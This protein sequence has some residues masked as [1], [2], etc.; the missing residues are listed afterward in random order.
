MEDSFDVEEM[1]GESAAIFNHFITQ[2][3]E[4][5]SIFWIRLL[6]ALDG[7]EAAT[8]YRQLKRDGKKRGIVEVVKDD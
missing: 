4:G 7:E 5:V 2:N 8:S 3:Y 1:T 6:A